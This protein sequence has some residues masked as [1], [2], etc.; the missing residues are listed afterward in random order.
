[1]KRLGLY[2]A[3]LLPAVVLGLWSVF[4]E[5]DPSFAAPLLHFYIVTFTTF[6]ATVVSLFVVISVGET[7]QPRHLLLAMAYAWMGAV[8]FIHGFTTPG[9][10]ITQFHPGITWSAWL[11]LFGG[12]VIFLASAFMPTEPDPRYLR[13]SATIIAL[14]Y[15]VYVA[16]VASS[17]NVLRDLQALPISPTLAELVFA[18]TL[19]IW[20]AASVRH[21]FNHRLSRNFI[22][23]LMAFEAAWYATAAVSMF[24]FQ[25]WHASWW[26]Y[27][28]LLLAGF[29]V[30]IYAL[31]RAYE[32]VRTFRL[33]HYYG[34]TSLIV[35]AALAL[36]AAHVYTELVFRNLRQ[37]LEADT[38]NLT[39][40][41][42]RVIAASLPDV[43]SAAESR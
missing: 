1:M 5:A 7:A 4:P 6:A 15:V 14:V 19:A 38:A 12:G 23:G 2:L 17:P 18:A 29:L 10:L 32:Q 33:T 3:V 25:L 16:L 9:A 43:T 13:R 30:A 37:Q 26:M 11:T 40:H 39:A 41:L 35:T 42:G 20:L 22:D 21:Y 36:M 8:F 31:W 34:A 24:R 28:L 27:H